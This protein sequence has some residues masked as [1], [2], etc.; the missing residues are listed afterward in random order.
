MKTHKPPN[1]NNFEEN[2]A[3][4]PSLPPEAGTDASIPTESSVVQQVEQ[5]AARRRT[6]RAQQAMTEDALAALQ[7]AA[8]EAVLTLRRNLGC[9]K[10][11]IE[12]RTAQIILDKAL[13]AMELLELQQRIER[14]EATPRGRYNP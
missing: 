12:N 9:G 10:P 4:E 1:G 6:R 13:K 8:Q 3:L 7:A 2:N 11:S 14:L 5:V